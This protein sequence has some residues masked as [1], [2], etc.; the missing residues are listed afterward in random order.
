MTKWGGGKSTLSNKALS[1]LGVVWIGP[2]LWCQHVA[3]GTILADRDQEQQEPGQVKTM[4]KHGYYY[5]C[6]WHSPLEL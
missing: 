1:S 4:Q 3:D 5:C 6:Q 2:D